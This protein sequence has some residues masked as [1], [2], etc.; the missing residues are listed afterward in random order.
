MSGQANRQLYIVDLVT[1]LLMVLIV[2]MQ[3][4]EEDE[5]EGP[6][7]MRAYVFKFEVRSPD[8]NTPGL[9]SPSMGVSFSFGQKE[10][11]VST[12]TGATK[13]PEV[14]IIDPDGRNILIQVLASPNQLQQNDAF[15]SF[16]PQNLNNL[17]N[18]S[19]EVEISYLDPEQTAELGRPSWVRVGQA[20]GESERALL[21]E[22][23]RLGPHALCSIDL[24]ALSQGSPA[25]WEVV[26]W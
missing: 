6:G 13:T 14:E 7:R 12:G 1:L 2:A 26:S 17:L 21:A 24:D 11:V 8:S 9:P 18:A 3:T 4:F 16:F 20:H 15:I 22:K 25:R 5:G 23:G 10:T 19:L